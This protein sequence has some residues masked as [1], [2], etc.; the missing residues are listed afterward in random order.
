MTYEPCQ[1]HRCWMLGGASSCL[2]S[3]SSRVRSST[4][5][6]EC[7]GF[8]KCV[9]QGCPHLC[10]R[11]GGRSCGPLAERPI[12]PAKGPGI[13]LGSFSTPSHF[14]SPPLW[15]GPCFMGSLRK[16]R[17]GQYDL[18]CARRRVSGGELE[19]SHCRWDFNCFRRKCASTIRTHHHTSA[20]MYESAYIPVHTCTY[21]HTYADIRRYVRRRNVTP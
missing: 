10:S 11:T 6:L 19:P 16:A 2:P 3:V 5:P 13:S 21:V 8:A 18:Y 4:I 1:A 12:R 15:K 7:N 17:Q 20:R 9:A 14:C